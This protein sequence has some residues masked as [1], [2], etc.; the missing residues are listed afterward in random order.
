[1]T[2]FYN[3][4]IRIARPCE[5]TGK[6]MNRNSLW[7][8][9]PCHIIEMAEWNMRIKSLKIESLQIQKPLHWH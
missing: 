6:E 3:S 1:M 2:V 5:T 9:E 7:E 4:A 8:G